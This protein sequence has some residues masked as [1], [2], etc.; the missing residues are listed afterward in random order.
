MSGSSTLTVLIAHG[1]RDPRWRQPFEQ[2]L[3]ELA[4]PA[5]LLCYMEMADPTLWDVVTPVMDGPNPVNE[6]VIWPLFMAA[7][8]HVANDITALAD[9]LLARYPG[10]TVT[11]LPP[12]GEHPVVR[13]A[14]RNLIQE[15][16]NAGTAR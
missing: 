6:V 9:Q 13:T 4:D 1:S 8:A 10:L 15:R 14:I 7:G 5:I 12:I 3:A 2:L 11:T 16:V